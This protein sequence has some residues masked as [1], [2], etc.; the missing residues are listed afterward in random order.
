VN[1][2]N[3]NGSAIFGPGSEWFWS[4]AQFIIVVVTLFGIY[5]QLHAQA[6]ANALQRWEALQ[7][8]W[9]S[10]RMIHARLTVALWR[11]HASGP[12]LSFEAQAAVNWL[13]GFFEDLSNLEEAGFLT[14]K[15]LE[16]SWGQPVIAFWALLAPTILEARAGSSTMFTGFERLARR[17]E[18]V[19]RRRGDDWSVPEAAIPEEVE[20]MIG[21]NTA[22]LRMLR[23]IATGVIPTDPR[24]DVTSAPVPG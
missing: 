22:R 6:S 23:D 5:R 4:M 2:V 12:T 13:G 10:E 24:P 8:K 20:T 16:Y 15:E 9:D 11:K 17:A 14:W 1:L 3:W 7:G 19:A 21:R 18:D